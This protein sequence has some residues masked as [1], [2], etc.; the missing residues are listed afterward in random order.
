MWRTV[1]IGDWNPLYTLVSQRKEII[2]AHPWHLLPST[3]LLAHMAQMNTSWPKVGALTFS[4][5]AFVEMVIVQKW[6]N[7]T[8]ETP[9]MET[10][11]TPN[12]L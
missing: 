11:A 9:R 12:V 2:L 8:M 6:R 1:N 7:A 10:G 4:E 3:L 5:S